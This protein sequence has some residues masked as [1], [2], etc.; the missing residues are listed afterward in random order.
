MEV[1]IESLH[2]VVDELRGIFL[3][4]LGQVEIEHR[5]FEAGVAEVAL[6]DAQVNPGF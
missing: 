4:L 2:H 3:A 1:M 5:S 6:D